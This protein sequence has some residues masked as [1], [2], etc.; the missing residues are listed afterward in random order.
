MAADVLV[1]IL[2]AWIE[3]KIK[4]REQ[5][6]EK[7]TFTKILKKEDGKI[8]WKWGPEKIE[9]FIRAMSPWPGAWTEVNLSPMIQDRKRLKILKAHLEDIRVNS[10]A[11]Q[12]ESLTKSKKKRALPIRVNSREDLQG[13]KRL[14]LDL[15]QLEGKKPVSWEE[16]QRGYPNFSLV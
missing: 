11:A 1:T 7:A 14:V 3:G 13:R 8:D 10:W 2:P 16:F 9:R 6:H 12:E 4:P 5:D 15:V